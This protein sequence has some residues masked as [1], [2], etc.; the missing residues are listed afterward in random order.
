MNKIAKISIVIFFIA[1]I[2]SC[3]SVSNTIKGIAGEGK[4]DTKTIIAGLKEALEVSTENSVSQA[5]KINGFL[6]NKAIKIL[7]PEKLQKTAETLKKLGFEKQVDEFIE[8]MN[9]A[10]EKA[11][12]EAKSIFIDAI[13]DMTFTDAK[14]ILK[15][16]DTAATDFFRKKTS[17]RLYKAFKPKIEESMKNVG[18]TNYYMNM[19]DRIKNLPIVNIEPPD[20]GDYVT[21][22]SLD[23]LFYLI[24]KEEKKIRKDPAARVTELLKKV[25]K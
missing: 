6:K 2:L 17:K 8:S 1:S 15:G 18:V 19:V 22:K 25:F 23:G 3:E 10:A 16:G 24:A 7:L 4:L 13:K 11:A 12:P 14:K 9:R 21:N 20:L 5:S